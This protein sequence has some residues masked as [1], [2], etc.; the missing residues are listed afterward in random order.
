MVVAVL[1]GIDAVVAI[2]AQASVR[3]S[4]GEN[5]TG[6]VGA[7]SGRWMEELPQPAS[8]TPLHGRVDERDERLDVAVGQRVIRDAKRID[9]HG[10]NLLRRGSTIIEELSSCTRSTMRRRLWNLHKAGATTPDEQ[11]RLFPT[12]YPSKLDRRA[13]ASRR[14]LG[15]ATTTSGTK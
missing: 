2:A 14:T 6:L 3:D 11:G 15:T 7:A 9:G 8:S 12:D 10:E 4:V 1:D 5:L 13:R